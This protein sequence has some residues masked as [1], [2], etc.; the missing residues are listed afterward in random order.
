MHDPICSNDLR[1]QGVSDAL[2]TQADTKERNPRREPRDHVIRNPCL[3]R[4]TR[5]RGNDQMSGMGRL[6]FVRA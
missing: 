3:H 5:S 4:R 2:V 1:S 6:D